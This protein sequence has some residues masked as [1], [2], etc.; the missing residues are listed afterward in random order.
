M[1]MN[2]YK[3]SSLHFLGSASV[4]LLVFILVRFVWYPDA[5]FS[6]VGGN[7]LMLMVL[8]VDLVL[9][10][11]MMLI[12]FNPTKKSLKLDVATVIFFQAVFMAFGLWSIYSAR[13]VYFVFVENRF[14]LVTANEIDT[15]DQIKA[16]REQF[17]AL[18]KLGPVLVGA[19]P[20]EDPKIRENIL[21]A[22][23]GGMGIQNLPQYFLPYTDIAEQVKKAAKTASDLSRIESADRQRLFVYQSSNKQA[24]FVPLLNK[25]KQ[26]YLAVDIN[27]GALV[28]IL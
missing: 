14:Y 7:E 12:I 21:F 3:A 5:L 25:R 6:A 1:R 4:V 19:A 10:P 9:G 22:S 16:R 11:L 15:E 18:P 26:L 27:T 2:R 13:P 23:L 8:S 28:E 24:Y 20:P 17:M